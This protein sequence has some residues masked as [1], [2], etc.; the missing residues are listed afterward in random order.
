[1]FAISK[2]LAHLVAL[3]ASACMHKEIPP[4][5]HACNGKT[6]APILLLALKYTSLFFLNTQDARAS[7]Y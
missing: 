4:N 6:E 7:L 3:L 2:F 5:A 1:L